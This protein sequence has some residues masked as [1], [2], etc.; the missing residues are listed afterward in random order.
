[1]TNQT[2]LSTPPKRNP[3]T[4]A[5]HRREIFWQV[6]FPLII[7]GLLL[8]AGII[9]LFVMIQ[10]E[11]KL[12]QIKLQAEASAIMGD[13]T[14][15]EA[16]IVYYQ[17]GTT[18]RLANISQIWL[19]LPVLLFSLLVM[20]ILIALVVLSTKLLGILPGYMVIAQNAFTLVHLRTRNVLD[21]VV[22]PILKA[23]SISAAALRA[24]HVAAQE[25]G[26][27]SMRFTRSRSG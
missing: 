18:A 24:R 13:V 16:A 8:L 27:L 14:S 3:L 23:K 7:A 17:R 10:N 12:E 25:L 11:M 21:V 20:G 19:L 4:H 2:E 5:K 22:E 6:T 9:A 26:N 15:E 1:M